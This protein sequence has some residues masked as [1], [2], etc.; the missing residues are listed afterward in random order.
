MIRIDHHG[1]TL[2]FDLDGDLPARL[3]H[4]GTS[5][6]AEVAPAPENAWAWRMVEV[7]AAGEDHDYIAAGRSAGTALGGRLR[8]IDWRDQMVEGGRRIEVEQRDPVT[9]LTV[10][11]CFQLF[12][13]VAAVES[14]TEVAGGTAPVNV[15][16]VSSAFLCGVVKGLSGGRGTRGELWIPDNGWYAEFQWRRASLSALGLNN[17]FA[18]GSRHVGAQSVGTWCSAN[19]LPMGYLQRSDGAGLLWEI[20][21]DGS[22]SWQVGETAHDLYLHIAGPTEQTG[23]WWRDMGPGDRM[24][25]V[26]VALAPSVHGF[27]GA[28]GGL[29]AWRRRRRTASMGNHPVVFNDY[30]NCLMG[31]PEEHSVMPLIDAAASVGAEVYCVDAGWYAEPGVR[32]SAVL[33]DWTPNKTRFPN[34]LGPVMDRIR[35][36]GMV[37]GLWFEIEVMTAS[38]SA[39]A[40]LPDDWFLKHH[41]RRW[42]AHRRHLLD[43]RNPEVRAF[44][45]RAVHSLVR[46]L[47]LGFLKLDYNT[48]SGH[49]PDDSQESPGAAL[50]DH[51]DAFLSWIDGLRRQFPDLMLEHCA[52]GGMRICQPFLSRMGLTS[53]SD[54]GDPQHV[55]RIA[56]AAPAII[57]PEQN[58][59]WALPRKEDPPEQV[60]F[61][62]VNAVLGRMNLAGDTAALAPDQL[63][64]VSEAVALHKTLRDEIAFALPVWPLGLPAWDDA[65]LCLGL[66]TKQRLLLA[67][68][69]R[70]GGS[71]GIEIQLPA[72]ATSVEQLYPTA[73]PTSWVERD[74]VL[75][76]ELAERS[77][78]LFGVTLALT[79]HVGNREQPPLQ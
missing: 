18:F 36:R 34:G 32:W 61:S 70:T 15:T 63:R 22:W 4:L 28:V 1:L 35:E 78:R 38:C 67:V 14:W 5:A 73:W 77:A 23:Q 3:V 74:G 20:L 55:A 53:N 33:G 58:G 7:A 62:M 2:I 71:G 64:L 52:S 11:S 40:T 51:Q 65:W 46:S 29:T 50:M 44:A 19:H 16:S 13:E 49:G 66:Q 76:V 30:M 26:R 37:P 43:F 39:F 9:G 75:K 56:A 47:G 25:T 8:P 45:E 68:W 17:N 21:H 42:V 12:D 59:T 57:P 6:G 79:P 10:T 54:Q 72:D 27:A 69:R 24:S 48:G 31:N 60:A 41:G